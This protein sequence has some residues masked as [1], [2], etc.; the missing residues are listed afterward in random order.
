MLRR[1]VSATSKTDPV[2]TPKTDPPRGCVVDG[3]HVGRHRRVARSRPAQRRH[4][5]TPGQ[6]D[7]RA[8]PLSTPSGCE[9]AGPDRHLT[10]TRPPRI[11]VFRRSTGR[12]AAAR[13][14][15]SRPPFRS[16]T[17]SIAG[18]DG[19]RTRAT[20]SSQ[21]LAVRLDLGLQ[22]ASL[23]DRGLGSQSGC[24]SLTRITSVLLAGAEP[25]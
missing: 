21:T 14:S 20:R 18:E 23:R 15:R 4:A 8:S 22:P 7:A 11:R 16:C 17:S 19:K 24:I 6:A 2:A 1:W 5:Y 25:R 13:G 12:N 9:G 3:L 10:R